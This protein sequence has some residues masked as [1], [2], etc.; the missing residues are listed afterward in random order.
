MT[1]LH[2]AATHLADLLERENAALQ[3]LDLPAATALLA[4]KR[5]ALA[6]FERA[7][8]ADSLA[9]ASAE[10][11]R[12]LAIRLRDAA[13]ENKRLLERAMAAQQYVM[14]LLAQAARQA[15]PGKRYGAQGAYVARGGSESAFALSARA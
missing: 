12:P 4:D 11:M 13:A 3:R 9:G 8:L 6:A 2:T 5:A 14:S 10:R 1:A 7:G 15:S